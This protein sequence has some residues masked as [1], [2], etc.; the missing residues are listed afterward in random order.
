MPT[1]P[2]EEAAS[3]VKQFK[4]SE[5]P[6][7]NGKLMEEQFISSFKQN[8]QA[9]TNLIMKPV[10]FITDPFKVCIV[11]DFI[12]CT[13]ILD[14]VRNEMYE[15]NW[16]KRN[17]DLYEFF[18]SKDLIKLENKFL[19]NTYEFLKNDIMEW[20]CKYSANL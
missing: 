15:L 5:N 7:L 20:V 18:Q 13:D 1:C 11:D 4:L 14:K 2:T 6:C 16:N 3:S 19:K 17:M 10:E 9:N 12:E 8:W